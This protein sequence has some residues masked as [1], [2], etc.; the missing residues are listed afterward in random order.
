[1]PHTKHALPEPLTVPWEHKPVSS[2]RSGAEGLPDGRTK[3]WIKHD[4][5][6]G[7]T[8]AML[9]WW[10]SNLEGDVDIEGRLLNRYRVWHPF[11]HVYARYT[12]RLPDGSIGP[13]AQIDV[14]E[15]LGGTQKYKLEVLTTIEK[16]DE[17]GYV[18]NPVVRDISLAR[19]EDTFREVAGGTLYDS[20]L[21]VPSGRRSWFFRK[22]VVP[23]LFPEPKGQ[24]WIK[25]T[26][27]AVGCFENFPPDLYRRETRQQSAASAA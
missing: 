25:H 5:A 7:V 26:V 10:F 9:V 13:G 19:M 27:E 24:A 21:I 11:D 18:H 6:K 16:L 22:I 17:E 14:L 2:A 4:L 3:F 15:Y 23:L 8:P 1:M 20:A 12:R